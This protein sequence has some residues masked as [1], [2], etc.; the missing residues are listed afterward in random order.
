MKTFKL[1]FAFSLTFIFSNYA[2]SQSSGIEALIGITQLKTQTSNDE[3]LSSKQQKSMVKNELTGIGEIDELYEAIL[4][5]NDPRIP[6]WAKSVAEQNPN[7]KITKSKLNKSSYGA[8]FNKLRK[9]DQNLLLFLVTVERYKLIKEEIDNVQSAKLDKATIE[10]LKKSLK[11]Q[12]E[13][14][15]SVKKREDDNESAV[16][17]KIN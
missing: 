14:A 12:E 16:I 13:L 17:G 7:E 5:E 8:G 1:I 11:E 3:A 6:A 10:K 15:T 4:I 2:F 9:S